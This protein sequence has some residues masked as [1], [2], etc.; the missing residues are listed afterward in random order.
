MTAPLFYVSTIRQRVYRP[1]EAPEKVRENACAREAEGIDPDSF[2]ELVFDFLKETEL[3]RG[4]RLETSGRDAPMWRIYD[5]GEGAGLVGS[6]VDVDKFLAFL[7]EQGDLSAAQVRRLRY[8]ERDGGISLRFH[9]RRGYG[10]GTVADS[11]FG[12]VEWPTAEI[13]EAQEALMTAWET[14]VQDLERRT[15]KALEA[16]YDYLTSWSTLAERLKDYGEGID[17]NGWPVPL[18][19]CQKGPDPDD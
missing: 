10:E 11:D 13:E 8:V 2:A 3:A 17:E 5:R 18:S 4:V 12:R 1:E 9:K 14:Y 19:E 7:A 15:V 16:E 6:V